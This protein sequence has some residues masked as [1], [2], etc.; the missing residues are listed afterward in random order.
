MQA[1]INRVA[2]IDSPIIS[3]TF[4]VNSDAIGA[5]TTDGV[6]LWDSTKPFPEFLAEMCKRMRL[7]KDTASIGYKFTGDPVRGNARHLLTVEDYELAMGEIRRKIRNARTKE[8]MLVL[9][10]LVCI[11]PT[12]LSKPQASNHHGFSGSETVRYC[13]KEKT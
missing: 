3:V 1:S 2:K 12:F 5:Q 13:I 6:C 9:K 7:D 8:H 10:N 11:S 4:P